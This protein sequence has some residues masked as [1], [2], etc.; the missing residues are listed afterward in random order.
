[1]TTGASL[2]APD[3]GAGNAPLAGVRVLSLGGKWAGRLASMLLADQGADVIEINNPDAPQSL[4]HALLSRGKS[5]IEI[6]LKSIEGQ[7]E[8][9][10]FAVGADIIIENL[11]VGRSARFALD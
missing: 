8:A 3:I 10:R 1:M 9:R 7:R 2:H 5:E 4:A 11:G 6:D